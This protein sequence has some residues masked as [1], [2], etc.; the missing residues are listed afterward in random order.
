MEWTQQ[1]QNTGQAS[2]FIGE[3]ISRG[4]DDAQALLVLIA[5]E[6]VARLGTRYLDERDPPSERELTPQARPNVL[7]EAGMALGKYPER[8]VL[9]QL[10]VTRIVTDLEG[11]HLIHMDDTPKKRNQLA[12]RL[13]DAGCDVDRSGVDWLKDGDFSAAI[14]PPDL[15]KLADQKAE[16]VDHHINTPQL[17]GQDA[18]DLKRIAKHILN[19]ITDNSFTVVSFDRIRKNINPRYTDELLLQLI[20]AMPDK[21]RRVRIAGGKSGIKK[22]LQ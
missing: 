5:G 16:I 3:V 11:R 12:Q 15:D 9:V 13:L 21:F 18:H 19:Y 22:L 7:F 20:D 14:Q 17:L 8:T 1:I 10:G 2:P 6:D 4:F